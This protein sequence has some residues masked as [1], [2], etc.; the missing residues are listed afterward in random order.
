VDVD[1]LVALQPDQ[2]RP[3]RRRQRLGDL[4]LAHARLAL[5]QQRLAERG[6]EEHRHGQRPIREVVLARE[7]L[8]D[9]LGAAQDLDQ[10]NAFSSARR[11]STRARWRL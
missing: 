7:R 11:V 10:A 4:R 6:G 2:P 1:P 8:A 3:V 9:R 5:Q